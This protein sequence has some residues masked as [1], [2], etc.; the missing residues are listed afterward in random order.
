VKWPISVLISPVL[1]LFQPTEEKEAGR[2]KASRI[3]IGLATSIATLALQ[4][5]SLD[6]KPQHLECE[7]LVPTFCLDSRCFMIKNR[8]NVTIKF[9]TGCCSSSVLVPGFNLFY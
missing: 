2:M 3:L 4:M 6:E 9:A 8:V 1:L 5:R 7:A